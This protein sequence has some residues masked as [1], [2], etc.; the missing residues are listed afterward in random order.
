VQDPGAHA[1]QPEQ[2]SDYCSSRH[3]EVWCLS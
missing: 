2:D 3:P 1:E